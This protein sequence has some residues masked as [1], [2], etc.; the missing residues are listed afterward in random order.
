[1]D[2]PYVN[3]IKV[4]RLLAY[5]RMDLPDMSSYWGTPEQITII[6]SAVTGILCLDADYAFIRYNDQAY[7]IYRED[8]DKMFEVEVL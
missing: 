2:N 6:P 5:M 8:F 1:M 7:K 3:R 4:Y